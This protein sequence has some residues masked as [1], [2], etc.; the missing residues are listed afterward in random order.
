MQTITTKYYGPAGNRPGRIKAQTSSGFSKFYNWDFGKS[1][2]Q[3]HSYSAVML[4]KQL[5]WDC[6]MI[7]TELSEGFVFIIDHPS[8]IRI[9]NTGQ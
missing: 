7:G 4:M 6:E 5:E 1:V 3:N 8:N 9:G 2:T